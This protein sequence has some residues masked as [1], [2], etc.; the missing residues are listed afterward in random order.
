MEEDGESLNY[1]KR[2][3]F[4]R[5]GKGSGSKHFC[6]AANFIAVG[7]QHTAISQAANLL[8]SSKYQNL[9]LHLH[10]KIIE[11]LLEKGTIVFHS[12]LSLIVEISFQYNFI[13]TYVWNARVVD[14]LR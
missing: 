4:N 5:W 2:G 12:L 14:L 10:T 13:L 3:M 11:G 6:I 9:I 8:Q 1:H 7:I